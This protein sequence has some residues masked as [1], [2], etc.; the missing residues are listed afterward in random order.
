MTLWCRPDQI[1]H[2]LGDAKVRILIENLHKF[3]A[4]GRRKL[5]RKFSDKGWNVRS[6]NKLLKKVRRSG[7]KTRRRRSG[8]RRSVRPDASLV[9]TRYSANI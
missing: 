7:S 9:F 2:Q 6:L 4:F 3:K 8:R 1:T 5:I